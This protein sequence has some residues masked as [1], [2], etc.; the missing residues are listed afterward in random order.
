M[1]SLPS[2]LKKL[3]NFSSKRASQTF[4]SRML[5]IISNICFFIGCKNNAISVIEIQRQGKKILSFKD[6]YNGNM[7]LFKIGDK[8]N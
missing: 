2:F 7:N 4:R 5:L 6:F 1:N 8:L 3:L